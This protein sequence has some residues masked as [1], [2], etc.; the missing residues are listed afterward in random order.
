MEQQG[1]NHENQE[2]HENHE[3]NVSQIQKRDPLSSDKLIKIF[4]GVLV[5]GVICTVLIAIVR[6]QWPNSSIA[7]LAP[8]NIN[9]IS[10][11]QP[12]LTTTKV[13][14]QDWRARFTLSADSGLQQAQVLAVQL[15]QQIFRHKWTVVTVLILLVLV[16]AGSVTGSILYNQNLERE[17]VAH[18]E[19]EAR[20]RLAVEEAES[21]RHEKDDL[22]ESDSLVK[23]LDWDYV[24][25]SR[26][27]LSWWRYRAPVMFVV[28]LLIC[29][30]VLKFNLM[31]CS[32]YFPEDR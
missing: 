14:P 15:K 16:I 11:N 21:Q 2:N 19:E 32:R 18:A 3:N 31:T 20:Q 28:V 22:V 7:F 25:A 1:E 4:T 27:W 29:E 13:K 17:A 8:A 5:I 30:Y 23:G 9:E 6:N 24:D 26:R 12:P 10:G